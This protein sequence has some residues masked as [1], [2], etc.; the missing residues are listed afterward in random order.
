ED[1]YF[2]VRAVANS[3]GKQIGALEICDVLSPEHPACNLIGDNRDA[4]ARALLARNWNNKLSLRRSHHPRAGHVAD[5]L[6]A[7]VI[8][9]PLHE[10]GFGAAT[11]GTLRKSADHVPYADRG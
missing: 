7:F 8:P 6:L 4:S 10:Q 1:F 9:K 3:F 5:L 2:G 11:R